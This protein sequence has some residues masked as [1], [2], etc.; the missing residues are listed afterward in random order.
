[1]KVCKRKVVN[2]KSI[3]R[4]Y[5]HIRRVNDLKLEVDWLGRHINVLKWNIFYESVFNVRNVWLRGRKVRI[6]SLFVCNFPFLLLLYYLF[7]CYLCSYRVYSIFQLLWSFIVNVELDVWLIV[8]IE[9]VELAICWKP[10]MD[11][12]FGMLKLNDLSAPNLSQ[13]VCFAILVVT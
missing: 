9:W 12:V 4:V 13:V 11:S 2:S 6:T 10:G 7:C 5:H 1:M 3:N 8:R